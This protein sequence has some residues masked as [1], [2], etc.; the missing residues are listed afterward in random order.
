MTS[1][2]RVLAAVAALTLALAGGTTPEPA[3][4]KDKVLDDLL[5]DLQLVPLEGQT[6]PAFTLERFADG[7]KVTLAE[8]RGRPLL[9]YFWATW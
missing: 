9:L 4:A 3:A 8:H 7:K 1:R 5:F 6:P 2:R